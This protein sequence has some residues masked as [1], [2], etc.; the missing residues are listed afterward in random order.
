MD[1]TAQ[2]IEGMLIKVG[3]LLR[4]IMVQSNLYIAAT[5]NTVIMVLYRLIIP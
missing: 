5:N 3:V 4:E 1:V 2:L